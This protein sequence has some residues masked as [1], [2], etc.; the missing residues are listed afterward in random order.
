MPTSIE[1]LDRRPSNEFLASPCLSAGAKVRLEGVLDRFFLALARRFPVIL[2][3]GLGFIFFLTVAGPLLATRAPAFSGAIHTLFRFSCHQIPD[4]CLTIGGGKA[5]V[6][7]RCQAI[8]A[9]T[10]LAGFLV[11]LG[12]P[13]RR[14]SGYWLLAA[15]IPIGL[16]GFTALLGL[17]ESTA[18]L[19]L[20][21]GFVWGI[22]VGGVAL[23]LIRDAIRELE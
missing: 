6:C 22:A 2:V 1:K 10:F 7:A 12:I 21:T 16:D 14:P 4:R 5:P 17:R 19:R 8:Y 20:S 13:R 18:P 3:A 11:V 9:G 15:A 23:G